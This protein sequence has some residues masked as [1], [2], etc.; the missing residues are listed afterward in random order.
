[1]SA[2]YDPGDSPLLTGPAA[3]LRTDSVVRDAYARVA[4]RLL[5]L[6]LPAFTDAIDVQDAKDAVAYQITHLLTAGASAFVA[7]S[8]SR[9]AISITYRAD[10]TISPIAAMLAGLVLTRNGRVDVTSSFGGW[11]TG[12]RTLRGYHSGALGTRYLTE[13]FIQP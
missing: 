12:P 1:M 2:T 7:S 10:V 6:I 8:E 13:Y 9:G 4:E 3:K 11:A 5:G